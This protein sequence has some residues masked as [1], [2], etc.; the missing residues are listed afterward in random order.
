MREIVSRVGWRAGD[1][2]DALVEREWLVTNGLG[3]YA[4]GTLAG[5]CTR[6]YHALL[7][8]ALPGVG[9]TVMLSTLRDALRLPDAGVHRL[10]AEER[11][12]GLELHGATHLVEFRLELGLPVWTY[13]VEGFTVEKRVVMPHGQNTVHVSYE[14]LAGPGA[15]TLELRPGVHFRPHDGPVSAPLQRYR[16]TAED[17]GRCEL[18]A[19][20][21]GLPAL[22][23][24]L[25]GARAAFVLEQQRL[26]ELV[27]RVER[28]RGY[29]AKGDL[30]SPGAFQVQ[31][32]P[33]RPVVLVA[34]AEP[35]EIATAL[36]PGAVRAA[37]RERRARLLERAPPAA[38]RGPAAVRSTAAGS[39]TTASTAQ[40]DEVP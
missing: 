1:A 26:A 32:A 15:C 17:D 23:V 35:W 38:Q 36:S 7:V 37:E 5:A 16:L 13:A 22:G 28:S 11:S 25:H 9:R 3:G 10:G 29:D 19:V 27:Y 18:L 30:W 14:L 4:S 33:G 21:S 24:Q 40:A 8:A 31:L 6:R 20:G 12:V 34:S 39:G 2:G